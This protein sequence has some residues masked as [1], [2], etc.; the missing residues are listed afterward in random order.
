MFSHGVI[1]VF[2]IFLRGF[3]RNKKNEKKNEN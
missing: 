3:N 1:Y 2:D